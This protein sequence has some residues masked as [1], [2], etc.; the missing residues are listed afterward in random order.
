MGRRSADA[1]GGSYSFNYKRAASISTKVSLAFSSYPKPTE[2]KVDLLVKDISPR[3]D[4][5]SSI[6]HYHPNALLTMANL[7]S[8]PE[9]E[10][11]YKGV[12]IQQR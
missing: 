4:T 7:P 6:H 11:A 9:F 8:E 10:Q 2:C 5:T 12:Y 3:L 1:T